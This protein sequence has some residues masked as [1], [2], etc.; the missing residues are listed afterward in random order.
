MK[1]ELSIEQ[2]LLVSD[3][4]ENCQLSRDQREQDLIEQFG[5]ETQSEDRYETDKMLKLWLDIENHLESFL[6]KLGYE[7]N[8]STCKFIFKKTEQIKK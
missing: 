6:E 7:Y 1:K 2:F 5:K 3:K 4:I 8:H